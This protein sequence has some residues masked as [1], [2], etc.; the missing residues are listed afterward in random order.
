MNLLKGQRFA[1]IGGKLWRAAPDGVGKA[2]P[3]DNVQ[4]P[5]MGLAFSSPC[6]WA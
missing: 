6:C 1:G 5:G 4:L 2:G 3:V